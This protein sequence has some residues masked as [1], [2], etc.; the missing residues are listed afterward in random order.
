MQYISLHIHYSYSAPDSISEVIREIM[1]T[2]RA[3]AERAMEETEHVICHQEQLHRFKEHEEERAKHFAAM[4][5]ELE[6]AEAKEKYSA[7]KGINE[8][9][10]E[11]GTKET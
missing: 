7:G 10:G 4:E 9:T 1:S 6:A 3:A 11:Q 5:A 8:G 2:G